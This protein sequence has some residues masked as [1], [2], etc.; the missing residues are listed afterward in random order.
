MNQEETLYDVVANYTEADRGTFIRKTYAHVA[1]ALFAFLAM[2]V[3][4]FNIPGLADSILSAIMGVSWLLVIGAFFGIT[5]VA[6]RLAN[7]S[8]SLGNQYIGL[9]LYVLAE[10]IIFVPLLAI[11]MNASGSLE[12]LGQA[13]IVTLALFGALTAVVFTTKT[14]FNYLGKSLMIGGFVALGMI[15]AGV[16]FGFNLGLAFSGFMVVL[17]AGTILY[18]TSNM[19]YRYHTSQYVAAALGLFASFMTLLWYIIRIF[20]SRD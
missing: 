8:T 17:V 5:W 10:A 15:I 12:L 6:E 13:F 20:M 3:A 9:F 1:L 2:E 7:S 14:D 11:A 18:Q 19:L 16:L 4:I